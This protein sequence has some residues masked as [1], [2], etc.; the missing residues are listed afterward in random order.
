MEN[1]KKTDTMDWGSGRVKGFSGKSLI[2]LKNGGFKMV[3]VDA[4][5]TY[6]LHLHPNTTEFIYVLEGQPKVT[7]GADIYNG[8]QGDFFTLPNAIKHSIENPTETECIL[9]VGAINT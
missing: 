9:L 8:S 7:I 4:L 2:D 3:K 1:Y 5:A 6:P